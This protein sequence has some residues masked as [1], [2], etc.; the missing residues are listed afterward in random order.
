MVWWIPRVLGDT[1][2]SSDSKKVK[3]AEKACAQQMRLLRRHLREVVNLEQLME[4]SIEA[5]G[6]M[7]LHLMKFRRRNE[8]CG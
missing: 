8:E 2:R 6:R 1:G 3:S 4:A 5:L 7:G